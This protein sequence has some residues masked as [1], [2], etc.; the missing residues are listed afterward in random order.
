MRL[1][2][3]G[4][5]WPIPASAT[6]V[7]DVVR[8]AM[9]QLSGMKRGMVALRINGEAVHPEDIPGRWCDRPLDASLEIELTSQPISEMVA[10]LLEELEKWLPELPASCSMLANVFQGDDPKSG[11]TYFQELA[12]LWSEIKHQEQQVVNALGLDL[13]NIRIDGQPLVELHERLNTRLQ[14]AAAAM[15][16]RDFVLLGDLLEY[17]LAPFAALETKIIAALAEANRQSQG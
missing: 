17:E 5:E 8:D 1:V 2:V 3:D 6:R 10:Q 9:D 7:M 12:R 4:K 15:E 11:F 14:E 16:K 13:E